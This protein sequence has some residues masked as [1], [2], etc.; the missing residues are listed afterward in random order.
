MAP[1]HAV[2][3]G[4]HAY[5]G[6]VEKRTLTP[7][8]TVAAGETMRVVMGRAFGETEAMA[9]SLALKALLFQLTAWRPVEEYRPEALEARWQFRFGHRSGVD[10]SGL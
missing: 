6:R 10:G 3:Y 5:D 2:E 8:Q 7:A 1:P 9:M 4:N